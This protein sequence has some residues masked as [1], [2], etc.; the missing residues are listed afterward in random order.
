MTVS[1]RLRG[2]RVDFEYEVRAML[3]ASRQAGQVAPPAHD[4][5]AQQK[6]LGDVAFDDVTIARVAQVP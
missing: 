5:Q 2:F 3:A 4:G 1:C 6:H